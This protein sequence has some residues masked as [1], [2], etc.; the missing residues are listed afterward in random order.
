MKKIISVM[1]AAV[2]AA[3]SAVSLCC[4]AAEDENKPFMYMKMKENEN[5]SEDSDGTFVIKREALKNDVEISADIYIQDET[6]TAWNVS[7]KWKCASPFLKLV[8][9]DNPIPKDDSPL[10]PFAYA[11]ADENGELKVGRSV[12]TLLS[13]NSQYNVISFTCSRQ[14]FGDYDPL[15]PYGEKSDD[16]PLIS[17]NA[18]FDKNIP[19][20]EYEIYFLTKAEDFSDQQ[21][22]NVAMRLPG[23][24]IYVPDIQGLRFRVEGYNLGD[25]N[26]DGFID[27]D[28]A[29]TVLTEYS[30][31]STGKG[32]SFS[33]DQKQAGDVV[34][35]GL[36]DADDASAILSYYSYLS[37]TTESDPIDLMQY[38][39]K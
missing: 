28:D 14:A 20:G 12:G 7:P 36:V 30:N 2:I 5:F 8:S 4:S 6:L 32:S 1:S 25:V 17:Y 15:V 27:A 29:S 24:P 39:N 9:A 31:V 38:V 22:T 11:A 34:S 13:I 26:N 18:V 19:A 37:T 10:L 21:F 3:L 35:D 33:E 16:Y 23:N